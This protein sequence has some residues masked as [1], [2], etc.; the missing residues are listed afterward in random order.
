VDYH[1]FQSRKLKAK[2]H[3]K[4]Y[5]KSFP[6]SAYAE[7]E[8]YGN[9]KSGREKI[10]NSSSVKT[11]YQRAKRTCVIIETEVIQD[12]LSYEDLV[13]F[14]EEKKTDVSCDE[15]EVNEFV[16]GGKSHFCVDLSHKDLLEISNGEMLSDKVINSFQ[17]LMKTQYNANGLQDTVLGQTLHYQI[18]RSEPFVQILHDGRIHWVVIST[19]GCNPGEVNLLDSLFNGRIAD[20]IKRQICANLNFT[21]D[22]LK[23]N[24]IP[25]QQ[26]TNGVD[27]GVL[28]YELKF[29]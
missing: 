6:R 12:N 19:Y 7:E 13:T 2:R 29:F 27:C 26:Q 11:H 21:G 23:I 10:K 5:Q 14:T 4:I 1:L 15:S 20:H 22:Q 25:V 3:K 18:Y 9:K 16:S 28:R 8:K 24:V 17:H